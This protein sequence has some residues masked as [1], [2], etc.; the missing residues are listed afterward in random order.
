MPSIKFIS[1]NRHCPIKREKLECATLNLPIKKDS[2]SKNVAVVPRSILS[3]GVK[4]EFLVPEPINQISMNSAPQEMELLMD[5]ISM[6]VLFLEKIISVQAADVLTNQKDSLVPAIEQVTIGQTVN[7]P[8]LMSA[9]YQQSIAMAANAK[10]L[11]AV[12][13]VLVLRY[14]LT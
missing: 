3:G 5:R 12:I 13:S 10:I 9:H 2:L 14:L 11:K 6:N 1:R 8:I 7:V 4:I